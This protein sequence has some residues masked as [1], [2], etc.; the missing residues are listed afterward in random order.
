MK[1]TALLILI[2]LTAAAAAAGQEAGPS[3]AVYLGVADYGAP[4]TVRAN[5]HLF[6]YRFL[7]DGR[8]TL[9]RIWPGERQPGG[10]YAYPIQNQLKEGYPYLI[11]VRNGLVVSAEE[12]P[13]KEAPLP[14]RRGVPG[15][16]TLGNFLRTASDP[17]GTALYVYGG[18]WD[19]QDEGASVQAR[20]IGVSPDWV[21]FFNE[22]DEYY[23]YKERDGD[24]SKADP[25]TS[26]YPY[27]G[28]NEYFYAGLDCS[29]FLGWTLYNVFETGSGKPGFVG[30][31]TGFAKRLAEAG[32]GAWTR[33]VKAPSSGNGFV[34]KPGDIMS[35][36]GHVWI[37][38]GTCADKSVVILHSSP[39]RSRK[40]QPGGGVQIAAIGRSR[41]CEAC[42]L[43]DKYVSR[44]HPEW[45]RRYPVMLAS[46]A[47][48]FAPGSPEAGRF[49]WDLSGRPGGLTD[50]DGVAR[51]APAEV[52]EFIYKEN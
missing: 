7:I 33:D 28:Y 40:G 11:H 45:Y 18:G 49:T 8:E 42:R 36:R 23:T 15:R 19:W 39:S 43:A 47:S 10:G 29:G 1:T 48:Y 31:S 27:G 37:S 44:Y 51:M 34:M 35:I 3:A 26:Y 52:L 22:K 14:P 32:L 20:T 5:I 17:A 21:R 41:D 6:R 50:P 13:V 12:R 24:K 38:L 46:P 2:L 4:G 9:L 30:S 25:R 16:R